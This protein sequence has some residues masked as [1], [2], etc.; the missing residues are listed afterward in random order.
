MPRA[1][2]ISIPL[3]TIIYVLA[4]VAYFSVLS[5]QEM[6]DSNAVAVVSLTGLAA[7]DKLGIIYMKVCRF[8]AMSM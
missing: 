3:V 1:I 2:W 6:L 8:C 7:F 4:N 5:A